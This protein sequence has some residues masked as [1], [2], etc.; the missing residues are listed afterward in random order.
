M[1]WRIKATVQKILGIHPRGAALHYRLQRRFGGLRDFRGEFATK[2]D[3]W[4]LMA[5]HLRNA[6]RAMQGARLMEIGSGWYPTFPLACYLCGARRVHTFDLTRHFRQELLR[7]C[8]AGMGGF[9]DLLAT[10]GECPR[11]EVDARYAALYA[12]LDQGLDVEA[13]TAGVVR[14]LAPADATAT[15][16]D[17][18]SVDVVFSNSVLEHVPPEVITAMYREALRILAPGGLMF[19]SVN[20]GD[21]YAY[22]DRNISQL[23]YLRYSDRAWRFWNN[24][25][26]Y[27]NRM[28]AHEFLDAAT[29]MGFE[30]VLDTSNPRPERLAELAAVPVHPQFRHVPPERLCLTSVDFIAR[31]PVHAPVTPSA[32][33]PALA[34]AEAG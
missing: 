29:G 6:G 31:R 19:H 27:Q 20:C 25:F 14:Y 22:V 9:L 13:A 34:T 24:A 26:L 15:G 10:A 3:D 7:E 28:R 12:A 1:H 30:L 18:A 32:R 2:M 5:G 4:R 11:Q 23:N 8:V 17:P 21:H 33:Q 16:L